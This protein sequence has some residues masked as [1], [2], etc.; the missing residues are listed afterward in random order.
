[1]SQIFHLKDGDVIE[2]IATGDVTAD[3][4]VS[5]NGNLGIALGSGSA[6]DAISVK[7]TGVIEAAKGAEAFSFGDAVQ[8]NAAPVNTIAASGDIAGGGVCVKDAATE[9][10]TVLVRLNG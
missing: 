8:A 5:V 10:A 4:F 7:L 2:M 9:D 3:D 6:G 1:M